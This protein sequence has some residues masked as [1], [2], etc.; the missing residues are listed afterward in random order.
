M[1]NEA[2]DG[3]YAVKQL[4]PVNPYPNIT[5]LMKQDLQDVS[6]KLIQNFRMIHAKNGVYVY[7]CLYDGAPAVVKY[8][9]KED[10]KREILNYRILTQHDIP[11]VKTLSLAK[12]TLVMEDISVSEHWRLGMEEDFEDV[13][14]AKS[15][16]QWY[17]TL[18]ENGTSVSELDTLYFEYD[19]I[20]EENLKILIQKF[21]EANELFQYVLTRYDR[22]Y[23][24]IYK[25][26]F[27][28][29]YNDFHW[30]NFV[31][32][33][34]KKAAMM[35]DFNLMGKGYRFSDFRNVYWFISKEAKTAFD[36]EY[37]RLYEK[38]MDI[39]ALKKSD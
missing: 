2:V 38:S 15:L 17:F 18:H 31:V 22:L 3:Y 7:R 21:P 37:R 20:T 6:P 13:E 28:L 35:F 10:D 11:T 29:T 39:S 32:R 1:V 34:D 14:V 5:K 26:S 9:E 27:T 25:P 33:K 4:N 8:F 12:A 19:S 23:E 36:D 24:L 30:A 16:A